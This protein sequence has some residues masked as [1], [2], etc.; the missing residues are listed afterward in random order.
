M[1]ENTKNILFIF[2][3]IIINILLIHKYNIFNGDDGVLIPHI[4]DYYFFHLKDSIICK[5]WPIHK[6]Y[7]QLLSDS[8]LYYFNLG[9]KLINLINLYFINIRFLSIILFL[10]SFIFIYRLNKDSRMT[11]WY[12]CIFLTL[13]PF[14]VMSHSI[15]HD[16]FIFS[17][18]SILLYILYNF[19]NFN[20]YSLTFLYV[21]WILLLTHPSGFPFI[22]VSLIYFFLFHKKKY[23]ILLPFG[24]LTIFSYLLLNDLS[25]NDII[26]LIKNRYTKEQEFLTEKA[27][28]FEKIYDYFWNAKYKRHLI[29]LIIFIPYF[30]LAFKFKKFSKI[31]KFIYL[32]PVMT[33]LLYQI[34]NY[35][36]VS[37]LKH[38]YLIFLFIY[39]KLNYDF[40]LKI[41]FRKKFKISLIKLSSISFIALYI[42]I[43]FIFLPHNS[44][45][46]LL[47]NKYKIDKYIQNEQL[48]VAAPLYYGFLYPEKSSKYLP[49][50]Q[51]GDQLC[52]KSINMKKELDIMIIDTKTLNSLKKKDPQFEYLGHYINKM[53][54][55]ESIKIGRLATQGLNTEGFLYIYKR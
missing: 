25:L 13:E 48:S 47:K 30:H 21:S 27:F 6:F 4:A 19:K 15:R 38:L 9:S 26:E 45:D 42:L 32:I 50:R 41:N 31:E 18:L 53:K 12:A 46:L 29:E 14:L 16:I 20:K 33:L 1:N 37:Y 7:L 28:T 35:F 51:L 55:V 34:L 52:K 3:L 8:Y 24:I 23:F 40:T 39:I 10:I 22:I 44:W 36:N 2:F 17:G 54:L 43:G 11:F 5:E 49:I